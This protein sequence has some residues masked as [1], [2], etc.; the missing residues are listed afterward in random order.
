MSNKEVKQLVLVF[1]TEQVQLL[2]FNSQV[3]LVSSSSV[4]SVQR[5]SECRCSAVVLSKVERFE[6]RTVEFL[7]K[8]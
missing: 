7:V 3:I 4:G 8:S 2:R 6:L 1:G 5:R